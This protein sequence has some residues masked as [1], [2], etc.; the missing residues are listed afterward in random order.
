M[1]SESRVWLV[2]GTSTGFGRA[3]AE[4]VVDKGD[5]LVA[6]V[7]RPETMEDLR[8][9]DPDRVRVAQCDVTDSDSV[10]AAVE[11]AVSEFGRLDFVVNNAGYGLLAGIEDASDEEIRKQIEV[12]LFGVFAV[13]RAALPVFRRQKSGHFFV[14]SSVAGQLGAPALAYYDASKFGVEG[15]AEALAAEASPINVKVTIIQPGN[16]RT[17]WAGASMVRSQPLPE[18]KPAID[19]IVQQFADLDGKQPGDP[20]KAAQVILRMADEPEPPLRLVLGGDA[21]ELIDMKLDTYAAERKAW[22][23]VTNETDFTD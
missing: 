18:Y 5:R 6:A 1:A 11:T 4:A 22:E 14:M 15:F 12:N 16:F 10:R 7:R 13:T 17:N 9:R 2:T 20:A 21:L 23:H 8:S 3:I 19:P